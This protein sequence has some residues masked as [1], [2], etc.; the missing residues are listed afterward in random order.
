MNTHMWESPFTPQQLG[1]LSTLGAV[2]VPPVSKRLACADVGMGAMAAPDDSAAACRRE[3]Q[4]QQQ[5]GG[6]GGG[7]GAGAPGA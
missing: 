1:A 5:R 6:V 2:V 3:L 4:Q 7:G